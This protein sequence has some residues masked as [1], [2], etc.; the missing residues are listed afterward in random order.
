VFQKLAEFRGDSKF[1]TCLISITVNQSLMKPRTQRTIREVSLDEYF[2]APGDVLPLDVPDRAPNPDQ[3]CWRFE[4]RDMFIKTLEELHP[5][6]RAVFILRAWKV[7]Q[8]IKPQK[9]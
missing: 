1:S 6:L 5:I 4:L 7:S 2:R 3:L 9:C 8:W